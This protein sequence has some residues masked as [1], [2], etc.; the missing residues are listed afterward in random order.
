MSLKIPAR[1]VDVGFPVC[2]WEHLVRKPD[3]ELTPKE[4]HQKM[5]LR[6]WKEQRRV[7]KA[8]KVA[9]IVRQQELE[10]SRRS[11]RRRKGLCSFEK[12][13]LE[14]EKIEKEGGS[15]QRDVWKSGVKG[16][17]TLLSKFEEEFATCVKD[18]VSRIKPSSKRSL[19]SS[20]AEPV[21]ENLNSPG[22]GIKGDS[23]EEKDGIDD[24]LL[25]YA[26]HSNGN[27]V[28]KE[29]ADTE[30]I[31]GSIRK[32]HEGRV[33]V[34]RK[35]GSTG[36]AITTHMQPKPDEFSRSVHR[37]GEAS[38]VNSQQDERFRTKT[39]GESSD[40]SSFH[41][42]DH[43]FSKRIPIERPTVG[44]PR[45]QNRI[46][47]NSLHSRDKVHA[48]AASED[49][50]GDG[51]SLDNLEGP[52]DWRVN[53]KTPRRKDRTV[54]HQIISRRKGEPLSTLLD[55]NSEYVTPR[56]YRMLEALH[57]DVTTEVWRKPVDETESLEWLVKELVGS[58]K[59]Q[60]F[61]LS[62]L[63]H[64]ARLKWTDSRLLEL[65]KMLGA[66]REWRRAMEVVNWVHHRE[67]FAHC[68]NR[69]VM[70]TLLAVLGKCHRPAEALDVFNAMREEHS[71]YPDMAAYHSIAVTL[72]QAGHLTQLLD[73]IESLREGPVKKTVKG[74]P[75]QLNW[76]GRLEPDIVVY[77]AV[78]NACVP[79]RQWEGTEWVFRQI[80]SS[81]I[82]PNSATYG[83]A[84]EVMV[85]SRQYD[86]VWRYYELMERGDFL[87]NASTFKALVEALGTAGEID[88]AIEVVDDM[89]RRG[90]LECAGVYYALAS[91]LC[92]AGRL[93]EALVQVEKLAKL[94][95]K[96][97]DVVT[98]TGLIHTCE[99]SGRWQDAIFLFD[100]ME[101]FVCAP[102][103]GTY[104]IMISLYGRHCLFEKAKNMF[105]LVKRGAHKESKF[106]QA[107]LSRLSPTEQTYESMLGACVV[108]K[109]W[110]YFEVVLEEFHT[111][112][113][114][115]E[116]RR[117]AWFLSPLTKAGQERLIHLMVM[118]LQRPNESPSADLYRLL[119]PLLSMHRQYNL[120]L[121]FLNVLLELGVALNTA[122]WSSIFGEALHKLP[123]LE[124]EQFICAKMAADE[125][126]DCKLVRTLLEC[127]ISVGAETKARRLV[128]LL[129]LQVGLLG[130][131]T[132]DAVGDPRLLPQE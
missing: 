1:R 81:R 18:A 53:P 94:P 37:A 90:I 28:V 73:L 9:E 109:E 80:Q 61:F 89:E 118:H 103:L 27:L 31:D 131:V 41:V 129:G 82:K 6:M 34:Q 79:H 91:A 30:V 16:K 60:K 45:L 38:S 101:Q 72:G 117:H 4:L 21:S 32:I 20:K 77:N 105:E 22:K 132:D 39:A 13:K 64:S 36:V 123:M 14:K 23:N 66:C 10:A 88:Q 69:H 49:A 108:C 114:H 96:K 74:S 2:R 44:N 92:T 78:I 52:R 19:E 102:N 71:T 48:G 87:P 120:T 107:N 127:L 112:G 29:T 122:E 65:V 86:K 58:S 17:S 43:S 57:K 5:K 115:L 47:R 62:R 26:F 25:A 93:S 75:R 55:N 56:T 7:R 121:N 59:K 70:T 68:R 119:L 54:G 50:S 83:L 85:K 130:T 100:H 125:V 3:S 46:A 113:F 97:L 98:Y 8:E 126:E 128:S 51:Y 104:N 95:T 35:E 63:M 106:Y 110:D 40:V 15:F 33:E 12:Y 116:C 24:W 42:I 124:L 11:P 111:R 76:N 84:T 99:K 67:H